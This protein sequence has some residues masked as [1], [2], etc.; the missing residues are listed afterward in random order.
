MRAMR[1]GLLLLLIL[2]AIGPLAFPVARAAPPPTLQR[3]PS[4]G[5]SSLEAGGNMT[6]SW[7]LGEGVS[8]F[9]FY[10]DVTGDVVD[11][12][13]NDAPYWQSLTGRGWR[14]CDGCQ[15]DAGTYDV[16]V[17]APFDAAQFDLTFYVV[18]QAPVD[19]AG[20]IPVDSSEP[21]SEFGAF[22]SSSSGNYT[23]VLSAAG[24]TYDFFIDNMLNATVTETTTLPLHIAEGF[25]K[26]A[27]DATGAGA[28]VT[29][30][31]G[32]QGEGSQPRL[33][34]AI[35]Y[36]QSDGCNA[37]LNPQAGQSVCVAGVMATPSD[38]G[39]PA[40][41]YLWKASGGEL[42]STS[43]QW[44]QWTAPPGVAAFNLTVQASASGYSP[45]S[46]SVNVQVV[47]EFPSLVMPLLLV[48]S[49]GFA[50]IARRR[51]KSPAA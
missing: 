32:I 23:F 17:S 12:N 45:G 46:S 1:T 27:V 9:L 47:P 18:P 34:V 10:Y 24:G 11:V 38:G 36:P 49:L 43:S 20:F 22:F 48:L 19:F 41:T 13:I 3:F 6:F 8:E 31:V 14:F 37:A 28:D 4:V 39:S 15:F 42:N 25:H 50:A 5:K 26:L 29:W 16:T 35:V 30:T 7:A 21:F 40:I 2:L 44:I 51:S 33:E